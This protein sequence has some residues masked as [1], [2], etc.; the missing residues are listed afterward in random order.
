MIKTLTIFSHIAT[1]KE[2]VEYTNQN[3]SK[4]KAIGRCLVENG[5]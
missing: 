3:Q 1:N 2:A 4:Q 5:F